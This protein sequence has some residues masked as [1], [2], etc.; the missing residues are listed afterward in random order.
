MFRTSKISLVFLILCATAFPGSFTLTGGGAG[1]LDQL[2]EPSGGCN[3]ND[4]ATWND[5]SGLF[6]CAVAPGASGGDGWSD[7]VDSDIVPTGADDTYDLGSASAQFKDGYFDGTLEADTITENG[8]ALA[9]KYIAAPSSTDNGV[10]RYDGTSGQVQNSDV[11]ID[12][13]SNVTGVSSITSTGSSASGGFVRVPNNVAH[14]WRNSGDSD[15][16]CFKVDGS[17]EWDFNGTPLSTTEL[18][19]LA[20][21]SGEIQ[22]QIDGKA[23]SDGDGIVDMIVG[24]L[25]DA[26]VKTYPLVGSAKYPFTINDITTDCV[27]GSITE[28]DVEIDGTDVTGLAAI[29]ATTTEQTDTASG[30]NT[31]SAGGRV[32]LNI[33]SISTPVDCEITI[34]IT[35]D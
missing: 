24:F 6:E 34:G 20:G 22:G 32:T 29:D 31:V 1:S 19:Y 23:P 10:C 12:D 30:A 11:A 26:K 28:F 3:D 16:V 35:R 2:A 13:S 14:C 15:N 8:D 7:P 21:L 5:S 25:E 4:V 18:G 33:A 17:D 9:S 27:S